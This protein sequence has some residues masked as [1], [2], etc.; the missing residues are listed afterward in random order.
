MKKLLLG[1]KKFFKRIFPPPV[2]TFMRE[3][4][5]LKAEKDDLWWWT[6]EWTRQ[7]D[8]HIAELGK[9]LNEK[10]DRLYE[11][12]ASANRENLRIFQ[13]SRQEREAMQSEREAMQGQLKT[14]LTENARLSER[15]DELAAQVQAE[16]TRIFQE[17]RQERDALLNRLKTA[18]ELNARLSEHL[19][20]LATQVQEENAQLSERLNELASQVQAGQLADRDASRELLSAVSKIGTELPNQALS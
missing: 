20:K 5:R 4:D 16:N 10:N 12:F 6:H 3:M 17:G 15:L 8:Q 14:A 1:I 11:L 18:M 9:T 19:D 7:N 13:E 2:H